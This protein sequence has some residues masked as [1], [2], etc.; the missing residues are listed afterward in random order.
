M[1]NPWKIGLLILGIA[2]ILWTAYAFTVPRLAMTWE[3]SNH[4]GGMFGGIGAL[5]SGL[6]LAGV[7]VAVLMQKEELELQRAELRKS[8]AAQTASSE[9]LQG[10]MR[11]LA[12]S[13]QITAISALII[14]EGNRTAARNASVGSRGIGSF[15]PDDD[16][17]REQIKIL[18]R[19][20]NPSST[21]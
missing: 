9:A 2:V 17:Y 20:L 10:Q 21:E 15:S 8:V 13:A 19:Q 3:K 4:F 11:L 12:V 14:S 7:V 18:L 1:K 5:F 6:A 16:A